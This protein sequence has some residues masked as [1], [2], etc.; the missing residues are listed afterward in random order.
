M[1]LLVVPTFFRS[2]SSKRTP[3]GAGVIR[4]K[5]SMPVQDQDAR[6]VMTTFFL[7]CAPMK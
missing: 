7:R 3:P 4:R 2:V 6:L 5:H 1:A